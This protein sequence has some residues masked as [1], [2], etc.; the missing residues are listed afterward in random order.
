MFETVKEK[1]EANGFAV[2]VFATGEEASAYLNREI[3]R[4]T[5]GISG[6]E[7]MNQL[8]LKDSLSAHNI[9]YNHGYSPCDST[10]ARDLAA[11]ADVYLLSANG[12]SESTGE[13]INIDGTGNRAA[14]SLYGHKKVY[15][16]IGRNKLAPDFHS[17]LQRARNIAGPK[18]AQR[19]HVKTPCAVKGDRCYDCSSPER[20][21]RGLVVLYQRM[22]SMDMEVVLIDQELG[23]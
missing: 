15:F 22:M 5:V 19:L 12:L 20:I 11:T 17:A 4:V 6:S 18:N 16:V 3:D 2:S 21:C 23:Y 13:I 10:R 7:T 9:V 8:G 1:L 14:S